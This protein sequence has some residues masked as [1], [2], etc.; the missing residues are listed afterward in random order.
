M[1]HLN[2]LE[3][4]SIYLL[5]ESYH[6]FK[7]QMS[8]LWSIG[9]DSTVMLHLVKKAFVG[10]IPFPLMHIDTS[11][12]I[13]EMLEF[14]DQCVKEQ[15]IDMIVGANREALKNSRSF[16]AGSLTRLECCQ[17]LKTEA[18]INTAEAKFSRLRFNHKNQ[19]Y[20]PDTQNEIFRALIMGIRADEEGSRSKE[21]YFSVRSK[22]SSWK[23]EDMPPELWNEFNTDFGDGQSYRIHPLLDWSE[24][25]IWEY[26]NQEKIKV[27]DLYFDRGSG[28]RYRSLGCAPCTQKIKSGAKTAAEIVIELSTGE[29]SRVS[30]RSG[31]AQDKENSNGLEALRRKGY[32]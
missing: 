5:R 16:P 20:E 30:E 4:K 24:K 31:R 9:K 11:Y 19:Q 25:N 32:M 27:S 8:M 17:T 12:K 13:N 26:I 21:R 28:E 18:L 10:N 23:I 29:L 14:R 6:H 22:N 1:T 15:K 3:E 2:Q 7:G